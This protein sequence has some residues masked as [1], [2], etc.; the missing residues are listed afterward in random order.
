MQDIILI[1]KILVK[2]GKKK[3]LIINISVVEIMRVYN[4][5]NFLL[6]YN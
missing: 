3:E 1:V 2:N 6:K 4:A 5:T